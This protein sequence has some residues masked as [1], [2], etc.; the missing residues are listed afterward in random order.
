MSRGAA[1]LHCDSPLTAKG[2]DQARQVGAILRGI[3]PAAAAWKV[4]SS[5]LGRTRATAEIVLGA[6][7]RA[8]DGYETD[9]RLRELDFGDWTGLRMADVEQE[10]PAEWSARAADP[11]NVPPPGGES[12]GQVA[13]RVAAWGA[14]QSGEV[15]AVAHGVVG[16]ILRGV[17]LGLDGSGIRTLDEPQDCVFRIE[18]SKVDCIR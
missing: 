14:E 7:G 12:Y 18:G 3:L 1:R 13:A 4:V 9:D 15:V 6:L 2:K 8:R 5:P 10:R 17:A 16:R 11:W